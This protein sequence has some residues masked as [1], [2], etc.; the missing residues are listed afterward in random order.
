MCSDDTGRTDTRPVNT[1]TAVQATEYV[2]SGYGTVGADEAGKTAAQSS[3]IA[4]ATVTAR[5]VSLAVRL[6]TGATG[7]GG[8]TVTAVAVHQV[9]AG[10]AVQTRVTGAFVYVPVASFT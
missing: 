6:R 5:V 3:T 10:A 8:R 9:I 7:V 2:T 4:S 1:R